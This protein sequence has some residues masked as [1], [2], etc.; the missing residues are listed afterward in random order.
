[1]SKKL[2]LTTFIMLFLLLLLVNAFANENSN[3]LITEDKQEIIYDPGTQAITCDIFNADIKHLLQLFADIQQMNVIFSSRVKGTFS[4]RLINVPIKVAFKIVLDSNG[5]G[6]EESENIIR[7]DTKAYLK[8][9]KSKK[10]KIQETELLAKDTITKTIPVNYGDINQLR[11][12]IS[13]VLT[14]TKGKVSVDQRTNQL[15]VTDI[16]ERFV[17]IEELVRRLDVPIP[18]VMIEAK[19][20]QL[21]NIETSH[22]G[23]YW[24]GTNAVNPVADPVVSGGQYTGDAPTGV[25]ATGMFQV[26]TGF[27]TDYAA[28]EATISQLAF[29]SKAKILSNPRIATL[30]N[31]TA[32]INI[33]NKIPLRMQAEDG[34]LTTQL[35]N[36]GTVI[37]VTPQINFENKIIMKIKPEVS[38]IAGAV[39]TGPL[40]D[41]N[42]VDTKIMVNDGDTAVIG[43]LVKNEVTK[44]EVAVPFFKDLPFIGKLFK[45][46][47]KNRDRIEILVFVTPRIIRNYE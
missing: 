20:V 5:L 16:P 26:Q 41:T 39:S 29:Q 43:G 1:M 47:D 36:V 9:E 32:K 46:S 23:I 10:L 4:G 7:I 33:G 22:L 44:S 2:R 40:I 25:L 30:N 17:V 37:T 6:T 34:T 42:Y 8:A 31:E 15:I 3:V 28:L 14:P 13:K 45:T 24:T 12:N 38:S 35:T 19:V 21:H 11:A 27:V 18:Q